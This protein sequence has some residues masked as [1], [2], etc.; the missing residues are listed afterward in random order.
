MLVCS[1]FHFSLF[2]NIGIK[3][4]VAAI[5][6]V[7]SLC[8]LY[9]KNDHYYYYKNLIVKKILEGHTVFKLDAVQHIKDMN[10]TDNKKRHI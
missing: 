5:I 3:I 6:S 10:G 1:L 9:R 4:S 2:V 8:G 7:L